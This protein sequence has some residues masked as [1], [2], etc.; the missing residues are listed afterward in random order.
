M[1]YMLSRSASVIKVIVT[2][3]ISSKVEG[4]LRYLSMTVFSLVLLVASRPVFELCLS[5]ADKILQC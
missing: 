1:T 4:I 3:L 2:N 5:S